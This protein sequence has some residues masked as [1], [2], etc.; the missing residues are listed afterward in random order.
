MFAELVL[1]SWPLV[2]L[3]LFK[4]MPLQEALVWS[5]VSAYLLLPLITAFDLP[6]VPPFDKQFVSNVSA[7]VMCVA[8]AVAQRRGPR[9]VQARHAGIANRPQG[10]APAERVFVVRRGR[11][12]FWGLL[13]LLFG[14]T[15]ITVLDNSKPLIQGLRILQGLKIYDMFSINFGLMIMLL[16]FLLA[17]RYL[18]TPESHLI[19]LKIFVVG[20]VAYSVLA[21]WEVRMSPQLNKQIYGF[22]NHKWGQAVRG[23]GYRPMVFMNHGLWLAILF[24]MSSIASMAI[25]RDQLKSAE[26]SKWL[27]ISIYLMAVLVLCKSL[28][29]LAILVMLLPLVFIFGVG[30]QLFIAAIISG[31]IIFYPMLRGADW[32]PTKTIANI[33]ASID[34]ARAHSIQYRFDN[35]DEL[36]AHA[37]KKPLSGWGS[38]GRNRVANEKGVESAA[39]DGYWVII[40]GVYGWLGYIAH[41]GL[42]IAPVVML[43]LN[44]RRFQLT[45]ATSGLAIVLVGALVDLIP[46]ATISP[47]TWLMAGALMGRYQTAE[48][49]VKEQNVRLAAKN[50]LK[51]AEPRDS[52]VMADRAQPERTTRPLHQRRPREG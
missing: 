46:N 2:T 24:A 42:L 16:P 48:A 12:L 4:R 9:M 15:L 8:F 31:I 27:F 6:L 41:F 43:A 13:L 28:G 18:A 45:H 19:L 36:L 25:W 22:A 40:V 1:Y 34:E 32:V 11:M 44:R 20:C 3:Y 35:E 7:T 37:N 33:T 17:R 5:V 50:P 51:P 30:M 38:W 21:L 49:V 14:T 47:I 10:A 52:P 39:T 23:G 29:A 26:S